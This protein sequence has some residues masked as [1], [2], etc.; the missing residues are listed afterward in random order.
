[1][2]SVFTYD[3]DPPRVSSPWSTPGSTTPSLRSTASGGLNIGL[4][5]GNAPDPSDPSYLACHG[6]TKLDVE[7]Q[8]GPTEYKLH[9]LLRPRRSFTSLSTGSLISGSNHSRSGHDVP[10]LPQEQYD[11]AS[12][13]PLSSSG[14]TRQHR[15]HQLTTQLL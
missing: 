4:Q 3:P 1:M 12:K 14:Q 5:D 8:D 9:L 11:S 15:L 6:I 2:A 10:Q 13:A 7:P